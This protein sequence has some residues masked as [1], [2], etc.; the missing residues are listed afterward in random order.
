MIEDPKDL[1]PKKELVAKEPTPL[2]KSLGELVFNYLDALH[3]E[4]TL[5]NSEELR[6]MYLPYIR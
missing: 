1:N 6:G 3:G 4:R 2:E 5:R